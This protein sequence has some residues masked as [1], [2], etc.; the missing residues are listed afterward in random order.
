MRHLIP[1]LAA[2]LLLIGCANAAETSGPVALSEKAQKALEKYEPVGKASCIPLSQVRSSRIIDETAIIY[3][4]SSKK[5]YV[6]QPAGGT[7]R[8]LKADRALVTRTTTGSL[9]SL[10]IVGVI[11]PPSPMHF[12]SCPLS[13]FTEYRRKP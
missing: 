9:C 3:E 10:D 12:G 11:D 6:N 7:C 4:V 2:P 5:W 13:E 1:T 8:A